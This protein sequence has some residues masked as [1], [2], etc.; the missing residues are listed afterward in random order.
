MKYII[1]LLV[2]FTISCSNK[3]GI[4]YETQGYT[5]NKY[6][7]CETLNTKDTI[8]KYKVKQEITDYYEIYYKRGKFKIGE[9]IINDF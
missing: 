5:F 2:I 1:I 4:I 8:Y 6:L 3:S 7:N 9:K